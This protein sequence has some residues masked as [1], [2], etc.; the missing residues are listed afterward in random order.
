MRAGLVTFGSIFSIN[1]DERLEVDD[2]R[3]TRV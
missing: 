1:H 3:V 2:Y